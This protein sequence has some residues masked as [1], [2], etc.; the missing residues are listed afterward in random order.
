MALRSG[1]GEITYGYRSHAVV[2]YHNR[3]HTLNNS[4]NG[5]RDRAAWNLFF[6]EKHDAREGV[7]NQRIH[8]SRT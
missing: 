2:V 5:V 4:D 7:V 3:V 1:E 8:Y 6:E